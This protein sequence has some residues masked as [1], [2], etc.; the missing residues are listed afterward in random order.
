MKLDGKYLTSLILEVL[1]ENE[2]SEEFDKLMNLVEKG[3]PIQAWEMHEYFTL[4]KDQIEQLRNAAGN[5]IVRNA[6]ADEVIPK[7]QE[8]DFDFHGQFTQVYG[9]TPPRDKQF[10]VEESATSWGNDQIAMR[11]K[12]GDKNELEFHF[13]WDDSNPDNPPRS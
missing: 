13:W 10:E 2:S 12:V 4:S 8:I 11:L 1:A 5:S 9:V 3:R 7:L 6:E